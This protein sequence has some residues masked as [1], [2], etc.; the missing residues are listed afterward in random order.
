MKNKR[1]A[2]ILVM[3]FLITNLLQSIPSSV[4]AVDITNSDGQETQEIEPG[5]LTATEDVSETPVPAGGGSIV[6]P[7]QDGNPEP[8]D[9]NDEPADGQLLAGRDSGSNLVVLSA[10]G[11]PS[12]GEDLPDLESDQL[13]D[14]ESDQLT[15]P[16]SDQDDDEESEE[17][18]IQITFDSRGGSSL[19]PITVEKG[20]PV[21]ELP[22]PTMEGFTFEG[23]FTEEYE[24]VELSFSPEEDITLYA[25]WDLVLTNPDHLLNPDDS[26]NGGAIDYSVLPLT[27][28]FSTPAMMRTRGTRSNNHPDQPC[29]VMLFKDAVPVDGMVNTWDVTL[30]IE[31]KNKPTTSDIVLVID[32][33]GSMGG[34]SGRMAAAIAA[35]NAF[36]D[37]LLPSDSIR[38]GIVTFAGNV[39]VKSG[40]SDDATAL[41]SIV[42]GLSA[43]GGT[44]TQAGVKQA[45]AMLENSNADLKNIVLLSDGEPTYSYGITKSYL[46]NTSYLQNYGSYYQTSTNMPAAAYTGSRVGAGNNM[47]NDSGETIGTWPFQRVVYYNHGNSAIAQAG[48]AKAAGNRLWTVAL[49][50]GNVGDQVLNSMA[51]P[52]SAYTASTGDLSAIFTNIAGQIG[53]AVQNAVVSDPMGQ[54]FEIPVGEVTNIT[55]SQG[56]ATYANKTINWNPGTLTTPIDSGSDI[57]YAEM[58]YR[59][60]INDDI[61]GVTPD[62]NGEYATNGETVV[63]YVD[64]D[65]NQRTDTFPVPKVN[66]VLYKVVKILKDKDGNE[67]TADRNFSID[68][69]GPGK[70]GADTVRK[71]VLNTSTTSG[72]KL[73]TDL[74]YQSTYGIEEAGNLDDYEV[75]YV[76][77]GEAATSFYIAD[78]NTEDVTVEVINKEKPG[79]LTVTKILDQSPVAEF[80]SLFDLR[81]SRGISL[82]NLGSV[83][84]DFTITGPNN[85]SETFTLPENNSWTKTFEGLAKGEYTVTET[86][87]GYTTSYQIN[88]DSWEN[89]TSAN[90]EID[91]G[92]LNQSVTFTNQQTENMEITGTKEWSDNSPTDKPDIWFQLIRVSEDD[93]ETKI[94]LP[95]KVTGDTVIWKQ[96]DSDLVPDLF[97]RYDEH[98]N[99]Y[100][101]KIQEVDEQGNDY[102][103]EGYSKTEEGLSITNNYSSKIDIPVRKVWDD[104][105]NQD[106]V[107]PE[108]VTIKLLADGVETDETLVLNETNN[109][110]GEFTSLDEYAS[111]EKIVYTV[112]E[113]AIGKGYTPTI[114]GDATEGYIVTNSRTPETVAVEGSKTWDDADNQDG[115]R[116]TSITVRLFNGTSEV[117]SKTV[118]ESD[119]WAWSFTDLAK[120]EAGVEITYTITED[121]VTDY[122]TTVS[123]Y[124]VTNSYT[125]GKIDIPVSKVWADANNQDGVRPEDVTIKLLAGGSDTGKTLTLTET[126]NWTGTFTGLDEY[127]SGE[128]IVYTVEEV[129]IGNGYSTSYDG[130]AATGYIVTNSR[131][132]E[133]IDIEGS[134]TWDDADNQDGK[135]PTSITIRLFNGTNEVDSQTID[136]D[137]GWAW[138]FT[139]LPKYE[140]GVEIIYTIT[141]D[142]ITDYNTTVSGYNVTNSY[143]PGKIDIPVSKVWDDANNQDGVRPEDVTIKLLADGVETGETLTLTAVNNWTGTFTD[144]DEYKAGVKIVYTVEELAIGNGYTTT[145]TGGAA[146]GY[147]VTNSRTPELIDIEGSK[148]WDD[149]D[150][151]DGKRPTSITIRLF[152]GTNEVDSTTVDVDDGWSWSFTD[153]PKYEAGVEI[154]Y[155]ITEDAITDYNTTVSGYNVTNSYTPGKTSVGVTKAWADGNNQDGVRPEDVTIKLLADGVD[156]GETLTLTAVNNWTGTFTDLDEYKAGVKIVYTVE[157]VAIGNGYTTTITG[158]AT[159]GYIVTNSRTPET[160]AVEGS[161]TWND[162][163]NK[164]GKRPTS[165]TVRLF[166]GTTELDSKTVGESDG[167]SW[168]FT[169]LPK[170]E[171]GVEIIYTITE[172]VIAEY[173]ATVYGH[174]ITNSYTPGKTSVQVT[175]AWADANNQ[176]NVRPEDVT[177]KLLADG[178]DTGETLTLTAINNWTGTFTDLDEYKDGLK[179]D[180]TVE[181]EAVGN[182]YVTSITGTHETGY[183]VINSRTPEMVAVEGSKTWNDTGNQSGKRPD[184]I[185]IRLLKNG[186]QTDS[187]TVNEDSGWSWSF[188]DLPKYEAGEKITYTITE[189]A[190]ASYSSEL[191][192]YDVTNTYTPDKTSVQVTKAWADGNNKDGVRPQSV[193]IKLIANAVD[194]GKTLI[195]SEANNWTGTF[196]DLDEYKDGLKIVYKV[197]E[198]KVKK[199]TTCITG[200]SDK[201]FIVTNSHEPIKKPGK[202]IT[203]TGENRPYQMAGILLLLAGGSLFA[204]RRKRNLEDSEN[205]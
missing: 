154:V 42:N 60:E 77:N 172:D 140:A 113:V 111:G 191:S 34:S 189:D 5:G 29:E 119:G 130:E 67:I 171:A 21:L 157:E 180:Y 10:L 41:K 115:K 174:D 107:R 136:V 142:A 91:I 12:D 197:E 90:V 85:Y 47:Y 195:L 8:D 132:P 178:V 106:G 192:G 126:N 139:D 28:F 110:T 75:S 100:E 98:G 133:L 17:E 63:N 114:T 185:T 160:V 9:L 155:T 187:K 129:A 25:E 104:A 169:D 48:F 173:S 26:P 16:E 40:L 143:T 201:G 53:A 165:I 112:E 148:T 116:P 175:K 14:S 163:K 49:S 24:K 150:N 27:D 151:Q 94:G 68:V 179:I 66:P 23:W 102:E 70:D 32:T 198:V 78:N 162:G 188:T 108:S 164:D 146:T 145:I 196:T 149:A 86:T 52:S 6:E 58:T 101:Y 13:T 99:E 55:T 89:G 71:F 51:S 96:T 22:S 204:W 205:E 84:F 3:L 72:T 194:T 123:G 64:V 39:Q 127:A 88:D 80:N 182:G 152:N 74:R 30:R 153:L 158:D 46:T 138:S 202:P 50:A 81:N 176:D 76:I 141:E 124:N 200:D 97:V 109:W 82:F 18:T 45:E 184:S 62:E 159:E 144:L 79:T 103:P 190:V 43:N 87:T 156:T 93:T 35:A 19:E 20:S 186:S 4:F 11:A 37:T 31:G 203:R 33:S 183:T 54:G 168:S 44:F 38:I 135:R 193:T 128:K 147:T 56:S 181:E 199:Y 57:K 92:A 177:I 61:L 120:Y 117:A 7:S 118:G 15:D 105:D 137:D 161:K 73:M 131:T 95:R 83:S 2:L 125:P 134:K 166:N 59:I 167:W 1:I 36:I 122:N 69:I 121:A 170:Y 65:G